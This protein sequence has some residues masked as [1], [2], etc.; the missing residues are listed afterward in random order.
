MTKTRTGIRRAATLASLLGLI[1]MFALSPLAVLAQDDVPAE[2]AEFDPAPYEAPDDDVEGS[3]SADGSSTV[4]PVTQAA[5]EEFSD[6]VEGVEITVDFSGTGGGFERF[7]EG[8]TD[9][10]NASRPINP[11]EV[12]ACT[13]NGVD[14]YVFEVAVDGLTVAVPESNDFLTCISVET[15]AEVWAPDS[16]ITNFHQIDPE[17]P[18]LEL[19]LYGPGPDSGTFDYFTEVIIGEEGATRE[20]YTPSEDDQVLVQG[21]ANSEGGLG[22]FGYAYYEENQDILNAVAIAQSPD[23]SDCVEPTPE[24]VQ[25]GT[26]APLSRPLF[27]YVRADSLQENEAVQEFMRFYL[28]NGEEIARLADYFGSPAEVYEAD[29]QRLEDAIS[30]TGTPDSQS[31][32]AA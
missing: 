4:F 32:P 15:L 5:A 19:E 29:R 2:G 12:A 13:E 6:I 21:V 8:E 20:D 23:L 7:C 25:D 1:A 9:I 30:G 16:E 24:T 27:V 22:Y 3:V 10:Q 17:F 28:A 14:Y 11:D 18:D 31:T 26:Y